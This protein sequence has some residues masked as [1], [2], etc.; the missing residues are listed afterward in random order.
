MYAY[1]I[2]GT[3]RTINIVNEAWKITMNTYDSCTS[4]GML[5]APFALPTPSSLQRWGPNK[6]EQGHEYARTRLLLIETITR[7][8]A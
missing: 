6:L 3:Y 2:P 7:L 4:C 5:Y 1:Y 8:L